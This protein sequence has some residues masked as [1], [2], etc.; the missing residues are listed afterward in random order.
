MLIAAVEEVL[1]RG[2]VLRRGRETFKERSSNW[3]ERA[4]LGRVCLPRVL[5]RGRP[6]PPGWAGWMALG[7]IWLGPLLKLFFFKI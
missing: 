1:E 4:A 6:G 3:R 5:V 2:K 7:P